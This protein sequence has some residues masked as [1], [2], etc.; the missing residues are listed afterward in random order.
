MCEV[1]VCVLHQVL[2]GRGAGVP[3]G[4]T[5]EAAPLRHRKRPRSRRRNGRP[6][7]QNRQDR[8]FDRL[9]GFTRRQNQDTELSSSTDSVKHTV[10]RHTTTTFTHTANFVSS[11]SDLTIWRDE[12]PNR[13]CRWSIN[14]YRRYHHLQRLWTSFLLSSF[15]WALWE[16]W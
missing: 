1:F 16:I 7:L 9:V 6:Q 2:L 12:L 10:N 13:Y 5:E 4:A 8:S 11:P 14:R 15:C 3:S